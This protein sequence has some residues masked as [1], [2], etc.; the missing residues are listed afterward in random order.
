MNDPVWV[1][2][3][4]EALEAMVD[5][6]HAG[7]VAAVTAVLDSETAAEAIPG[8]VLWWVDSLFAVTRP[9]TP[10]FVPATVPGVSDAQMWALRMMAARANDDFEE[11][12][13]VFDEAFSADCDLLIEYLGTLLTVV[14]QKL[15][16]TRAHRA[17]YN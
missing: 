8:M 10:A 13:R 11:A 16:G 3:A 5:G 7:A 1:G 17:R 4:R 6:N 12:Q 9:L 15:R 2:R 14:A